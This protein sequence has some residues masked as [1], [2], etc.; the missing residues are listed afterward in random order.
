MSSIV[1]LKIYRLDS[2]SAACIQFKILDQFKKAV[3]KQLDPS[4]YGCK[5]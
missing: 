5:A 1:S 2:S 3:F 4:L